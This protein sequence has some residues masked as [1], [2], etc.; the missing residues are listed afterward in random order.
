MD[1]AD[2]FSDYILERTPLP[3]QQGALW[4]GIGGGWGV[5]LFTLL[6][7]C[8]FACARQPAPPRVADSTATANSV[9]QMEGKHIRTFRGPA[10]ILGDTTKNARNAPLK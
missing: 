9:R 8:T 5:V 7:M 2:D 1:Y 6:L 4:A 10:D 3:M